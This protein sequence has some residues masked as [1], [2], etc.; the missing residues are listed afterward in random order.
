MPNQKRTTRA[1][2]VMKSRGVRDM[3]QVHTLNPKFNDEEKG[4]S[5]GVVDI[6]RMCVR[7]GSIPL[8]LFTHSRCMHMGVLALGPSVTFSS[9]ASHCWWWT[10]HDS[11][12]P[13]YPLLTPLRGIA[14]AALFRFSS[15]G[16]ATCQ[17]LM[18]ACHH[19]GKCE[20]CLCPFLHF[21]HLVTS[22][23]PKILFRC[24]PTCLLNLLPRT[25][26]ARRTAEQSAINQTKAIIVGSSSSIVFAHHLANNSIKPA[27]DLESRDSYRVHRVSIELKLVYLLKF[28]DEEKGH[29]GGAA[30]V[31]RMCVCGSA[32]FHRYSSS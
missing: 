29:S 6:S 23:W 4:H 30:D 7:L 26:D 8:V 18:K 12:S 24:R 13:W 28:H 10:C 15:S 17:L 3:S 19:Q 27:L 9:S 16:V 22:F 11:L 32:P 2:F 31:S 1:V 20:D 21:Q 25:L 5:G 14:C